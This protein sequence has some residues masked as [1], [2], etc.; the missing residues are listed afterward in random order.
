MQVWKIGENCF[1]KLTDDLVIENYP[2]LKRI[3]VKKESLMNLN[4]LK[5]CNCE[6]LKTIEIE[7][8]ENTVKHGDY[9]FAGVFSNVKNVNIESKYKCGFNINTFL[10]YNHS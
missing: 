5:I 10:I 3:V 6:K 9:Y 4:S 2:S 1:N 8:G 7:D